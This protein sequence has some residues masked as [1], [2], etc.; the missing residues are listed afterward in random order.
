LFPGS[1]QGSVSQPVKPVQTKPSSIV[2]VVEQPSPAARFPSSHCSPV[3]TL[4]S[5]QTVAHARV[6]VESRQDGSLLQV[7]EQPRADSIGAPVKSP[8]NLPAAA[9][10]PSSHDSPASVTPLPQMD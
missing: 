7:F 1:A 9:F 5:P 6:P 2:H 8:F 3:S 10:V 4:P